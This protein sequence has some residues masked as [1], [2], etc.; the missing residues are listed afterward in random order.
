AQMC[1]A[2]NVSGGNGGG[3]RCPV[4]SDYTQYSGINGFIG[5]GG[6]AGMGGQGG[7]DGNLRAQGNSSTC[8]L[9]GPPMFGADGAAGQPGGHG[10]GVAGCASSAGSVVANN[11]V[12][13]TAAS[14][15]GGANGA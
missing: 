13:G 12:N 3:N 9:P 1:G 4:A 10:A 8:F 2:A 14:G 7:W 11:W 5:S 6:G 15:T